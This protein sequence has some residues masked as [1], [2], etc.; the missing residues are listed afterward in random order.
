VKNNFAKLA[1]VLEQQDNRSDYRLSI[2]GYGEGRIA[3]FVM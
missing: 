2:P 1:E 3:F